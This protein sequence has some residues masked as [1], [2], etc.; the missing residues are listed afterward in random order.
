MELHCPKPA[1]F[2]T[3]GDR[4]AASDTDSGTLLGRIGSKLHIIGR[5][6]ALKTFGDSSDG[7]AMAHP[8]LR[9]RFKSLEQGIGCIHRCQMGASILSRVGLLHL[10]SKGVRDKLCTIADAK[11]WQTTNK[12]T[13]IHLESLG[14][15]HRVG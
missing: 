1:V 4:L 6:N 11:H 10:A 5:G 12:L 7:I 8:H 2:S 15:V 13:E 9:I 14:V 3:E